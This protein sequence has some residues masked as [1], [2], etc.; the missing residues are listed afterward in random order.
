MPNN[1]EIYYTISGKGFPVILLHGYCETYHMWDSFQKKLSKHYTVICPDLPGFGKSRLALKD[2][3]IADIAKIIA[4]WIKRLNI[5]PCILMGHSL[6]GYIALALAN[7]YPELLSGMGL[8]HSSAFADE[9]E[10]KITRDKTIA[11]IQKVGTGKFIDSFFPSLFQPEN[12]KKPIV[13]KAIESLSKCGQTLDTN[14]VVHY[15]KA[16]RNRPASLDVLKNF[17]KPVLFIAGDNDAKVPLNRSIAQSKIPTNATS[18][19]LK[20]TGH[21]GM[22][23]KETEMLRIIDDF[24]SNTIAPSGR[25]KKL[26]KKVLL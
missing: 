4:D 16:M 9:E 21:M 26:L 22:F 10:K 17:E 8:I 12:L 23:E 11:F 18:F 5:Q 15:M 19:I 7:R 1:S 2:F 13:K 25:Q 3:S 6:G 24:I 20:N 14:H